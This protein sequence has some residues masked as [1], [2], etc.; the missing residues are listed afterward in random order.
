[1]NISRRAVA[2][3]AAVLVV[4]AGGREHAVAGELFGTEALRRGVSGVVVDGLCRDSRT[5]ADLASDLLA[6]AGHGGASS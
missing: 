2:I 4:A 3:A 5:L 1:M 6:A